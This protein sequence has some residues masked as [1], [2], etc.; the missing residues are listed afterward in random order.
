MISKTKFLSA[1]FMILSVYMA[2]GQNSCHGSMLHGKIWQCSQIGS[3]S[4]CK[5]HY[6]M[7]PVVPGYYNCSWTGSCTM[8]V[9]GCDFNSST[10]LV[11]QDTEI[12]NDDDN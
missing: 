2:Y 1:A 3:K 10:S 8:D 6:M 11:D 12:D 7:R 4:A 5:R 9:L